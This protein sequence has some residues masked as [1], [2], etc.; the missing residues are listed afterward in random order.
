MQM[1]TIQSISDLKKAQQH[2][3]QEPVIVSNGNQKQIL[4]DYEQY[5][6]LSNT[7]SNKPFVSAYD[8]Y[9]QIMSDFS[10]EELE[11][12]A[13]DDIEFDMSFSEGR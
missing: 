12:L 11:I 5:E 7:K 2:A 9:M 4:M 3:E 1:I 10:Q 8:A 6:Q 13:C